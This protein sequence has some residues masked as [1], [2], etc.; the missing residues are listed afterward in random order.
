MHDALAAQNKEA[1]IRP[2][3]ECGETILQTRSA[4]A[5]DPKAEVYRLW[6]ITS[7]NILGGAGLTYVESEDGL[8]W[9]KPALRQKEFNGFLESNF[10]TL[11][12]VFE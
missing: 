10:V 3:L 6:I 12:P 1:V 8:H 2:N 9:Y 11:A 7:A 5:W 4:S